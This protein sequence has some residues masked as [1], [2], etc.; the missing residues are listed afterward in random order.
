MWWHTLLFSFFKDLFHLYEYSVAVFKH[1]R[2]EHQISFIDGCEPP[3]D[4]WELNSG[5]LEVGLVLLT[6]EPSLQPGGTHL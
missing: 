3:C 2:K 5:P 1:T 6:A 4:C